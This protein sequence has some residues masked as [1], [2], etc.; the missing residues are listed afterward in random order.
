[1]EFIDGRIVNAGIWE[2][3]KQTG[4]LSKLVSSIKG[5][6]VGESS[7]RNSLYQAKI[8]PKVRDACLSTYKVAPAEFDKMVKIY[9]TE[10]EI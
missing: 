5:L 1:M 4:S 9:M 3:I 6:D 10:E 7:I 8:S 2:C